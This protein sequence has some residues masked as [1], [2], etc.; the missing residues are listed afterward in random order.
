M[1][2]LGR[3]LLPVAVLCASGLLTA[4]CSS[5][6]GSEDS[7]GA[8]KERFPD[9]QRVHV[10]VEILDASN[11]CEPED[12]V[13]SDPACDLPFIGNDVALVEKTGDAISH[14]DPIQVAN[15]GAAWATDLYSEATFDDSLTVKVPGC[16]DGKVTIDPNGKTMTSPDET[17]HNTY[18]DTAYY[19]ELR[20]VG[21]GGAPKCQPAGTLAP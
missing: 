7:G 4:G 3:L 18:L 1:N 5:S 6:H 13:P 20:D 21:P 16:P 10:R 2:R 17:D 15:L 9:A 8:P 19:L 11:T 12:G 14:G